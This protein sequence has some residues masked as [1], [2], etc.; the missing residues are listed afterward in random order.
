[1]ARRSRV[2]INLAAL[3]EVKAGLADG[4]FDLARAIV[5]VAENNAPEGE[6]PKGRRYHLAEMGGAEVYV[7]G[8][9]TH[10]Y[11][12]TGRRPDLPKGVGVRA[13]G[14]IIG[15]AGFGFPG[16]FVEM[17]TVNMPAQPFLT[18]AA[19]DVLGSEARVILSAAMMRRLAGQRSPNTA[20]IRAR[21]A[22]SRAAKAGGGQ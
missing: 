7:G 13:R 9:R 20:K 10:E 19:S 15:I 1:M 5:V 8:K 6:L 22:A 17:G 2:E 11:S 4:V 14:G 16:M 12:S 3:D 21:I 18:P